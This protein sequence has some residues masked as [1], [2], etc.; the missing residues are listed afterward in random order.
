MR[1]PSKNT[2]KKI[3]KDTGAGIGYGLRRGSY[4]IHNTVGARLYIMSKE[5]ICNIG[6]KG[7]QKYIKQSKLPKE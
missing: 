6:M 3:F 1:N 7:Y 2:I 5:K 4:F